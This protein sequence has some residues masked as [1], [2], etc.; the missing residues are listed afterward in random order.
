MYF[1]RTLRYHTWP[2]VAL[3]ARRSVRVTD[4]QWAKIEPHPSTPPAQPSRV[5][6]P[7]IG[8]RAVIDGILWVLKTGRA[9]VRPAERVSESGD[10]LASAQTLGRG[11]DVGTHLARVPRRARRARAPRVGDR[12]HRWHLRRRRKRGL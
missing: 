6:G 12:V 8:N 5:A 9:V 1:P 2:E 11:R 7:W 10:V 3:V 4:A